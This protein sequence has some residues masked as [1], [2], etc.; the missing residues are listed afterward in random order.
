MIIV[1]EEYINTNGTNKQGEILIPIG[2]LL[3][4]LVSLLMFMIP[5]KMLVKFSGL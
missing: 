2:I 3:T 5:I 4:A 1:N